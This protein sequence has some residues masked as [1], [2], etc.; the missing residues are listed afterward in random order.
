MTHTLVIEIKN[1]ERTLVD[2][3]KAI[4]VNLEEVL[5]YLGVPEA[6]I[7]KNLRLSSSNFTLKLQCNNLSDKIPKLG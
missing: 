3:S 4:P 7:L 6:Y 1:M 2:D 5:S